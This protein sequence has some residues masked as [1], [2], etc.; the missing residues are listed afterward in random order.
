[1]ATMSKDELERCVQEAGERDMM[2]FQSGI[3]L[4]KNLRA[5]MSRY[6]LKTKEEQDEKL[7][8]ENASGAVFSLMQYC[9]AAEAP[10]NLC[11]DGKGGNF[12]AV[13]LKN[14]RY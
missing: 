11:P 7:L 10:E 1:M 12:D 9:P 5:A 3:I 2:N 4:L 8:A 13:M 14:L 6:G